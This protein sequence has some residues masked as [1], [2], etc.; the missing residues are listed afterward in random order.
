[1]Y[2]CTLVQERDIIKRL[3]GAT[4]EVVYPLL[5]P[6]IFA[7][8]E[9][10]RHADLVDKMAMKLETKI[11]GFQFSPDELK[12]P[13]DFEEKNKRNEEKR[14]DWLDAVYLK[15]SLLTWKSQ[16]LK[17]INHT[18]E[19]EE[20]HYGEQMM[21]MAGRIDSDKRCQISKL[22][23]QAPPERTKHADFDSVNRVT[24]MEEEL[25]SEYEMTPPGRV[26]S[27][28]TR[29]N[30]GIPTD[31]ISEKDYA[32]DDE[33]S[34]IST[35]SNIQS[36]ERTQVGRASEHARQA[37]QS[38]KKIRDRLLSI[39]DEYDDWVRDCSMRVEGMA[40]ATQW[41]SRSAIRFPIPIEDL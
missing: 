7:E 2:G 16:L 24:H 27:D 22:R 19:L 26:D 10:A 38:G 6:G 5:M 23:E 35:D 15:N 14:T 40:M 36:Y 32:S 28:M 21:N 17:L 31:R 20:K 33:C 30:D 13:V 1:M 39:Q 37:K 34:Q 11:R 29:V 8:L 3:Q 41:V 4:K 12:G 18:H 9:R 25:P